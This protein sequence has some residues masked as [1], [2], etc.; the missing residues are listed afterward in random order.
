MRFFNM[1]DKPADQQSVKQGGGYWHIP[2]AYMKKVRKMTLNEVR[3]ECLRLAAALVDQRNAN[4]IL[5]ERIQK[6]EQEL[7]AIKPTE[8]V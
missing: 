4:Y 6:I 7:K 2:N 1:S 5:S 8:G 3:A